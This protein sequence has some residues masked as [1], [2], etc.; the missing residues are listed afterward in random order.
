MPRRCRISSAAR[1]GVRRPRRAGRRPRVRAPLASSKLVCSAAHGIHARARSRRAERCRGRG[2][3]AGRGAPLRPRN[4]VRSAVHDVCRPPRSRKATRSPNSVF[5]GLRASSA[6]VVRLELGD[7]PCG[8]C[9]AARRAR[10]PTPRRRSTDSRRGPARTVRRASARETFSGVVERRRT[11]R[12]QLDAVVAYARS[13]CSPGRG[14]RRTSTRR[15]GSA[16][17]S[18]P[19]TRRVSSSRT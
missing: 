17:P 5:H 7:D 13:G 2:R 14:A 11:G 12:G 15:R 9:R 8:A 6:P 3:R 18:A 10:A 16:A 4:S 19:R 1:C